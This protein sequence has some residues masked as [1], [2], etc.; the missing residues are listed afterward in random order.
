MAAYIK[1]ESEQGPTHYMASQHSQQAAVAAK[2]KAS[3]RQK[4]PNHEACQSAC[5]RR[6]W[7]AH[8]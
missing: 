2:V 6:M 1:A 4:V 7:A 5:Q 3:V 8:T